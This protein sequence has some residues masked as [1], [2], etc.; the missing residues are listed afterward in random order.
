MAYSFIDLAREILKSTSAPLTY[1]QMWEAGKLAGL[2]GKV[3]TKGKTPWHTLGAQMY[4]EI[5]KN[6]I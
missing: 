4:V 5:K 1:Q 2:T 6:D 3:K